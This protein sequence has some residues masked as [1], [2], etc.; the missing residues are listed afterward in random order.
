[1]LPEILIVVEGGVI[2]Y[3]GS[4][5]PIKITI[6]DYDVDEETGT[7]FEGEDCREWEVEPDEIVEKLQ[8]AT[9]A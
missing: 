1:M 3:I 7:T 4:T 6:R 8:Y 9:Q 5:I 2:Q